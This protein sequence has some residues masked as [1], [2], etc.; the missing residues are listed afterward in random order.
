MPKNSKCKKINQDIN[1]IKEKW[2]IIL[3]CKQKSFALENVVTRRKIF[4]N[5]SKLKE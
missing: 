2:L 3:K 4:K 1:F 5:S